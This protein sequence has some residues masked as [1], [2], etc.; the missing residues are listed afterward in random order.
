M[1]VY[2]VVTV[3]TTLPPSGC[4]GKQWVRYVIAN[5]ITSVTGIRKGSLHQVTQYAKEFVAELNKKYEF[6]HGKKPGRYAYPI[7]SDEGFAFS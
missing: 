4:Q 2:R 7:N 5:D 6:L 3:E 1:S